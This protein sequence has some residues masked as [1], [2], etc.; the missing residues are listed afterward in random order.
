MHLASYQK[1][2][3]GFACRDQTSVHLIA[4]IRRYNVYENISHK[5]Q[6]AY[7]ILALLINLHKR[8]LHKTTQIMWLNFF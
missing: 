6:Y 8:Y 7:I 2:G 3:E 5:G 1:E 4:P